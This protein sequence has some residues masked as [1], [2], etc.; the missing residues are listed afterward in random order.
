MYLFIK[1]G[2]EKWHLESLQHGKVRF[3]PARMFIDEEKKTK[4][5]GV[6]DKQEASFV[7]P[8]SKWYFQDPDSGEWLPA[9][10]ASNSTLT[11]DYL[12][13]IPIFCLYTITGD[14][15]EV[16]AE[17]GGHYKV[18]VV[19]SEKDKELLKKDFPKYEHSLLIHATSFINRFNEE[20][21]K[22]DIGYRHQLVQYDDYLKGNKE[23][24]S[25]YKEKGNIGPIFWKSDL[26]KQQR[27]YRFALKD[28]VTGVS[29]Y[30]IQDIS[31]FSCHITREELFNEDFNLWIVKDIPKV[32]SES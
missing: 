15:L 17:E 14:S 8:E 25:S 23:R 16:I 19:F 7:F 6:G 2:E 29:V 22:K 3:N 26:Y 21:K 13:K 20:M 4:E 18:K 11:L 5:K 27:E 1:F 30:D 12:A 28:Q 10:E 31:D 9:F 24:F 32:E